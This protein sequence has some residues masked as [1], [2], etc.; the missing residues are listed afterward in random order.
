MIEIA[1][2]I[3]NAH[4][5]RIE[6][7][8]YDEA[9]ENRWVIMQKTPQDPY[10][11]QG[12]FDSETLAL[13]A[14]Q[15]LTSEFTNFPTPQLK[16]VIEADWK[17]AYKAYLKPWSYGKLHWVPV[18]EK[19][20]YYVPEGDHAIWVDAG[21]AFGTGTHETTQLCAIRLVELNKYLSPQELQASK[22]IDA[23]C[24]T[25][26]LAISASLLGFG[27]VEAFDNDPE[28]VTVALENIQNNTPPKP[29]NCFTADLSS[30]LPVASYSIIVANI[31]ANVLCDNAAIL[32][33]ALEPKGTLILSG[34][35]TTEIAALM[36]HFQ[37]IAHTLNLSCLLETRSLGEWSD[38]LMTLH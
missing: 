8:I 36:T 23:G 11:L 12:F 7:L 14:W 27:H 15:S 4:I 16:P 18:W 28:A 38:C 37:T 20:N 22:L 2:I 35:L 24:G 33:K 6:E 5:E 13:A 32:L 25:A 17:N 21:M 10:T 1:A 31:L 29:I 9:Y 26:I 19:P 30:G 34:I 3:D